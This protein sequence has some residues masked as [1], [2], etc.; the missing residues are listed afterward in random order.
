MEWFVE[1][2][3][4]VNQWGAGSLEILKA[5][6]IWQDGRQTDTA[7]RS[8]RAAA[9]EEGK[10]RMGATRVLSTKASHIVPVR[11]NEA[12]KNYNGGWGGGETIKR[13]LITAFVG[14]TFS[15]WVFT[16][17]CIKA[18]P[19]IIRM[20]TLN[21]MQIVVANKQFC[22]HAPIFCNWLGTAD[23]NNTCKYVYFR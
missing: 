9:N 16:C 14:A 15:P 12:G 21:C 4:L 8:G 1:G 10:K 11:V 22:V 17:Q 18:Q 23:M 3:Q 5:L 19:C 20:N 7:R 13:K 2:W 6:L